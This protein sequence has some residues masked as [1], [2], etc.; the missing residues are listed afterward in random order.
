MFNLK[1]IKYLNKILG[2]SALLLILGTFLLFNSKL[3]SAITV[4]VI[5]SGCFGVQMILLRKYEV[6]LENDQKDLCDAIAGSFVWKKYNPIKYTSGG[7]LE[8]VIGCVNTLLH[9]ID[10]SWQSELS[11]ND[12]KLN[13]HEIVLM[14]AL[15]EKEQVYKQLVATKEKLVH[16][17]KMASLGQLSAGVAHEINNP[18]GYVSNNVAVLA[19]YCKKIKLFFDNVKDSS[20]NCI[21]VSKLDRIFQDMTLIFEDMN[22]GL[23][24]VKNIVL[25]LKSFARETDDEHE[26]ININDVVESALNLTF[27]EI[28]YKAEL[29][30]EYGEVPKVSAST[31]RLSQVF[32]NLLINAAHAVD[33]NGTINIK[34]YCDDIKVYARVEDDGHGIK[35]EYLDKIF[36]PF[37]TTKEVGSGT[38]LGLSV[39][40]D[41]VKKINGDI[42]C[43]SKV[44]TGSCFTVSVPIAQ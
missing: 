21:D 4:I 40:Y 26:L 38:G 8:K 3:Y 2:I 16:S 14:N 17:E 36:D 5:A 37:F 22:S 12:V 1:K 20:K 25:D 6:A 32:V 23:D 10:D 35:K 11:N 33:K 13:Q 7:E 42:T 19:K 27:N 29:K 9:D 34:T 43:E 18:I 39:C 24:R 28:K 44:G 41:I 15:A 31:H 30:K